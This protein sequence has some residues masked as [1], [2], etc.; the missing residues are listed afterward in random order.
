MAISSGWLSPSVPWGPC[1]FTCAKWFSHVGPG[2]QSLSLSSPPRQHVTRTFMSGCD[3]GVAVRRPLWH[4]IICSFIG[5]HGITTCRTLS[6][7]GLK[8][9]EEAWVIADRK[10]R[11]I[12]VYFAFP[13]TDSIL[14]S[15]W[16]IM[17]QFWC[18]PN[19][20]LVVWIGAS[21]LFSHIFSLLIP[22]I[23]IFSL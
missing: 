12:G 4:V 14:T 15:R 16:I 6:Q 17:V 1:H 19:G 18:Y 23:R 7:A 11:H 3:S 8:R 9:Q 22:K 20:L 5:A 10:Q 21:W 13:D 2:E